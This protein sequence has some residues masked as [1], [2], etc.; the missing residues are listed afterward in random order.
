M[1][2]RAENL[3]SGN[4]MII[5]TEK[6]EVDAINRAINTHRRYKS[7]CNVEHFYLRRKRSARNRQM[8]VENSDEERRSADEKDN[9]SRDDPLQEL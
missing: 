8:S 3:M 6:E 1:R 4:Q 9:V 5:H 7:N 2:F